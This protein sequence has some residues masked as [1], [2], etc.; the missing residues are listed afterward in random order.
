V[1]LPTQHHAILWTVLRRAVLLDGMEKRCEARKDERLVVTITGMDKNGQSFAQEAVA[2][3]I[4]ESGA[5]LSGITK[6]VRPGDLVWVEF[7][8]QRSRFNVVW[9]RDSE[10][11]QLIQVAIHRLAS[12]PSPWANL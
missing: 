3:R 2:S 6:Q 1:S 11:H 9:V 5:L 10:S 12:E 8:G 7:R 4:S